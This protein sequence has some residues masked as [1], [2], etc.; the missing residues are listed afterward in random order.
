M[1]STSPSKA[2]IAFAVLACLLLLFSAVL[3]VDP[4]VVDCDTE[5][6]LNRR[7][8][9]AQAS[10]HF[11][12]VGLGFAVVATA[13]AANRGV[14]AVAASQPTPAAAGPPAPQWSPAQQAAGTGPQQQWQG[15][16]PWQPQ[17]PGQRPSDGTS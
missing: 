16:P 8:R 10:M 11:S 5:G 2:A 13:F 6:C 9:Y 15:Q 7:A 14:R 3:A 4:L 1:P 12:L 17:R